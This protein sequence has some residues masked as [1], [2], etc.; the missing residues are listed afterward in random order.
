MTE[1]P[2]LQESQLPFSLRYP[3]SLSSKQRRA[4]YEGQVRAF[5]EASEIVEIDE[6]ILDDIL[7]GFDDFDHEVSDDAA[8][9]QSFVPGRNL[10]QD[11]VGNIELRLP[12]GFYVYFGPQGMATPSTIGHG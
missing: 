3:S 12:Y 11:A 6:E 8:S 4:V 5:L 9:E 10:G 7:D 2:T 1:N